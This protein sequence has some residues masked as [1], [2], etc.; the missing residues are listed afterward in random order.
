MSSDSIILKGV[1]LN[2]PSE[3]GL[4]SS[5]KNLISKSDDDFKALQGIELKIK[6]GEVFGLI[7]KNGSGK[8]TILRIIAGIYA[9]DSGTCE[10]N[11]TTS[12]LA[13]IGTGFSQY[14]QKCFSGVEKYRKPQAKL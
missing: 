11:G 7:G 8:S 14:S 9:P 5:L 13:G 6:S 12:L 1:N 4:L 2:F 10:V 3:K